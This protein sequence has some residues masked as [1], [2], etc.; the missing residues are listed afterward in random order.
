MK[1]AADRLVQK[2]S[3]VRAKVLKEITQKVQA[4]VEAARRTGQMEAKDDKEIIRRA[5]EEALKKAE[6]MD[7]EEENKEINKLSN[8]LSKKSKKDE[9]EI[10][11]HAAQKEEIAPKP[12]VAPVSKPQ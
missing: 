4:E 11:Q 12:V 9:P 2:E 5:K 7:I 6:Q 1:A 10:P 3:E 8:D